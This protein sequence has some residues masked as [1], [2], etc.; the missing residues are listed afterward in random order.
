[1]RFSYIFRITVLLAGPSL[2]CA[3]PQQQYAP[4]P[5]QQYAPQP[6]QQYAPQPQQQGNQQPPMQQYTGATPPEFTVDESPTV[7]LLLH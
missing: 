4:Q 1:M 7:V 5:Q 2:L 3:Q 6:Q